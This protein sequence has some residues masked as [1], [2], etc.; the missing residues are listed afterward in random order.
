RTLDDVRPLRGRRGPMAVRRRS[1]DKEDPMFRK[2]ILPAAL[3]FALFAVPASARPRSTPD[4]VVHR[5]WRWLTG[6]CG[7]D[8][9]DHRS[10]SD[11]NGNATACGDASAG[12]KARICIDPNG[13][14]TACGP[15]GAQADAG[16]CIDPN[17]GTCPR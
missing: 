3:I 11:P 13:S 10:C 17:G 6:L 5:A 9:P 14:P 4:D 7:L 16:G 8:D 2:A 15:A 12:L 1:A